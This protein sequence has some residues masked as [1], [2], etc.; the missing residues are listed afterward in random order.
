MAL[1]GQIT[2]DEL[3]VLEVTADPST[4]GNGIIA[5]QG[6]IALLNSSRGAWQKVGPNDTDWAKINPDRKSGFLT[7]GDFSGNPK[8]A[9]V[10]F[11]IAFP[12]TNFA[13]FINGSTDVRNWT[14][15]SVTSSGFVINTNANKA[16]TG[17]VSWTA[18]LNEETS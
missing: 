3:N 5:P 4:A 16:L 15:E 10:A 18:E 2:L 17:N 7:A 1:K 14:Y 12:T 13:V 8:T 11:S 9:S 6:S